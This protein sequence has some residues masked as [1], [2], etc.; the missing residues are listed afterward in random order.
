MTGPT[1]PVPPQALA[2][3]FGTPS[4]VYDLDRVAAARDDL[5]AALPDEVEVFYAAKANPHPELLSEL[6]TGAARG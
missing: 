3:R 5:F 1:E 2:E 4:Y 6:R